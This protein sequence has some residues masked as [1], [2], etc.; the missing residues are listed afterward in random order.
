MYLIHLFFDSKDIISGNV[1]LRNTGC[2]STDKPFIGSVTLR[3]VV[4]LDSQLKI[5]ALLTSSTGIFSRKRVTLCEE[6]VEM[7]FFPNVCSMFSFNRAEIGKR[8]AVSIINECLKYRPHFQTVML[9]MELELFIL[10]SPN[11]PRS[12]LLQ[13]KNL[14]CK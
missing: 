9:V 6:R 7:A 12:S 8:L 2:M 14:L 13:Q 10:L 5:I 4:T 11:A 1:I 3:V